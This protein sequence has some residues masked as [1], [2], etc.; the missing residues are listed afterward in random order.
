VEVN[1]KELESI[2]EHNPPPGW[3]LEFRWNFGFG[4][5]GRISDLPEPELKSGA[6]LDKSTSGSSVSVKSAKF[7]CTE[8]LL[9]SLNGASLLSQ[10]HCSW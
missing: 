7:G 6:T 1:S 4:K 5:N 10:E 3:H 9:F 8:R 2:R